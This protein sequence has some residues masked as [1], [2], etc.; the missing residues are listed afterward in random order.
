MFSAK[1]LGLDIPG[2]PRIKALH[3]HNLKSMYTPSNKTS[4]STTVTPAQQAATVAAN[5]IKAPVSSTV[6]HSNVPDRKQAI[7]RKI[8]SDPV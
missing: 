5:S 4:S 1:K 6:M 7:K 2:Q 8:N 3:Q